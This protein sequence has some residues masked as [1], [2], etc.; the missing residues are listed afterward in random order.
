MMVRCEGKGSVL[1]SYNSSFSLDMRKV[2][3]VEERK[4]SLPPSRENIENTS[5]GG[6]FYTE[7]LLSADRGPQK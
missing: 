6:L 4:Q 7:Q 2:K 5:T 3:M 1:L